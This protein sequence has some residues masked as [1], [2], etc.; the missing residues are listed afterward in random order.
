MRRRGSLAAALLALASLT[1]TAESTIAF[2]DLQT[3]QSHDVRALENRLDPDT[4]KKYGDRPFEQLAEAYPRERPRHTTLIAR[5]QGNFENAPAFSFSFE[6]EYRH[7]WIMTNLSYQQRREGLALVGI[8]ASGRQTQSLEAA[9]AFLRPNIPIASTL[10]LLGLICETLFIAVTFIA[11]LRT[12]VKRRWIW[13][14]LSLVG[15]TR[16][17]LNWSNG[18]FGFQPLYI[19][20]PGATVTYPNGPNT[21]A[22]YADY[23]WM[24]FICIPIGAIMY[25]LV[26]A[27]RVAR[28]AGT[29][30]HAALLPDHE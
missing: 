13:A 4:R 18:A 28:A 22:S 20:T 26:R 8:H 24:L 1:S 15:V 12:R 29:F 6:S 9:N 7:A 16:F 23:P 19:G 10:F 27:E 11:A 14:I 30:T 17:F 3:A 21:F 2:R 5:S 25:W